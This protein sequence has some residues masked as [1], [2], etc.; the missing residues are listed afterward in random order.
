MMQDSYLCFYTTTWNGVN[1]TQWAIIFVINNLDTV[2]LM[3]I[4]VVS[5]I[6]KIYDLQK[7]NLYQVN[8]VA[9]EK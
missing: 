8:M 3:R 6:F 4:L 2:N 1:A 5:N 7:M 9:N